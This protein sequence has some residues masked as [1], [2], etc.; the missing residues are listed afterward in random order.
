MLEP[1]DPTGFYGVS[2][3]LHT[4]AKGKLTYDVMD[5]WLT[6]PQYYLLIVTLCYRNERISEAAVVG[7][8]VGLRQARILEV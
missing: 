5:V 4:S 8:L 7:P 1:E 3:C 2:G 6:L